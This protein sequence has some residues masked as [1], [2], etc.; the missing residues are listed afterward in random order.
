M[1]HISIVS[2]DALPLLVPNVSGGIGG[3][4]VRAVTFAR[5]LQRSGSYEIDFVLADR[6]EMP[7]AVDGFRLLPYRK[8]RTAPLKK[9]RRSIETRLTG[10]P[11][12]DAFFSRLES[13]IVLC[14]GLRND[15]ASIVRACRESG[16]KTVLFLTSDRNLVDA[17]RRGRRNR[18]MYGE[19]G[20]LCRYSLH[21]ADCIA[22]QSPF[23][24]DELHRT[25]GLVGH[26][27]RNPID[28]TKRGIDSGPFDRPVALWVGRADTFSKRA[29]LCI[30]VARLVPNVE[31][32][33]IMNNHDPSTF[34]AIAASAPENVRIIERVPFDEIENQYAS[35]TLLINTSSAEGFP[36]SFLQAAKYGSPIVSLDVDPGD[37]LGKFGGG[38]CACGDLNRMAKM[39]SSLCH[40]AALYQRYSRQAEE[41][42]QRYHAAEGRCRELDSILQTLT[43]RTH[44][45]AA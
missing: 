30:E 4:E 3:A 17:Q 38:Y 7:Q 35:A 18:G 24:L 13:E 32:R 34:D 8:S 15:T 41:Y 9:M 39:I 37:M 33:M 45:H 5:G 27:I 21:A 14:F 1:T 6:S 42:V 2:F 19:L 25:Q 44:Q 36:N 28:L 20:H 43:D 29:D 40:D 23:Q 10:R 11:H 12:A 16:K 22:V 31:F 26:L